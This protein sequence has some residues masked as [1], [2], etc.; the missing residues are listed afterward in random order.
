MPFPH[1]ASDVSGASWSWGSCHASFD[2]RYLDCLQCSLL[3]LYARIELSSSKNNMLQNEQDL[4]SEPLSKPSTGPSIL[5]LYMKIDSHTCAFFL[6]LT[7]IIHR[8]YENIQIP[9]LTLV[10]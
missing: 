6:A 2:H 7:R 10:P 9:G 4:T 8:P 1:L 3:L 5:S